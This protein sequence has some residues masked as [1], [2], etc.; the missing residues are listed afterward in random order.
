M[1]NLGQ[2]LKDIR[3]KMG[4]NQTEFGE[5]L[6]KSRSAYQ[7]L[8]NNQTSPPFEEIKRIAEVLQIPVHDLVPEL[9]SFTN[10]QN[11]GHIGVMF[12]ET[13]TIQTYNASTDDTHRDLTAENTILKEKIALL[14]EQN[15]LLHNLLERMNVK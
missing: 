9:I 5:M 10:Q 12:V 13:M 1:S 4:L 8:E 7:A 14:E 6:G 2:K 15:R 11:S 3:E